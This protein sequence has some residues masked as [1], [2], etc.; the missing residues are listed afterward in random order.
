MGKK[1]CINND[2]TW[3]DLNGELVVLNSKNGD[4]HMFNEVGRLIWLALVDNQNT[5]D[6][7]T[8]IT[9]S[10]EVDFDHA[11]KDVQNF[12]HDIAQRG[13]LK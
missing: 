7:A 6:I 5:S 11:L 9:E 12:V 8:S 1:L 13:L 4:Y 10:F 2:L 3:R